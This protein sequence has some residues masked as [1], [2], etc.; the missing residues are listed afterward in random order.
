MFNIMLLVSNISD[1]KSVH[2]EWLINHGPLHI[3]MQPTWQLLLTS[4]KEVL[5]SLACVVTW[6][7]VTQLAISGY[8]LNNIYKM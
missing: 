2:H 5:L 6:Q 3:P 1:V 7:M 4:L 8:T